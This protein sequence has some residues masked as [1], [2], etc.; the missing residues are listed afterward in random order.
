[1]LSC[2]SR[3]IFVF[4]IWHVKI[5]PTTSTS[6]K[7]LDGILKRNPY[8][9]YWNPKNTGNALGSFEVLNA[10]FNQLPN[11]SNPYSLATWLQSSAQE[12]HS[13]AGDPDWSPAPH[14]CFEGSTISSPESDWTCQGGIVDTISTYWSILFNYHNHYTTYRAAICIELWWEMLGWN[15]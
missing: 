15:I 4:D 1:M 3:S 5:F 9:S 14:G 12:W 13:E 2:R 10:Q 8:S 11:P 7:G 6:C